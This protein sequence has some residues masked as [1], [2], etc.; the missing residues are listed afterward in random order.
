MQLTKD[1]NKREFDSKDGSA[2]PA[3]I[4]KNVKELAANLQVLR[5]FVGKPITINSGYRSKAYNATIRGAASNSQHIYGCAADI[6]VQGM[7]P[8]KVGQIIENLI[9]QG[10]M[11]QG[12]LAIYDTFVHYDTRGNKARWDYRL[13]KK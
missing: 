5:D 1:F 8:E 7:K 6:V 11:K 12:G 9:N 4:L 10:K 3:D 2:M 13:K